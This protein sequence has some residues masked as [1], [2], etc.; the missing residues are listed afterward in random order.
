MSF[1]EVLNRGNEFLEEYPRTSP[2]WNIFSQITCFS[3]VAASKIL[4]SIAYKPQIYN[5]ERLDDAL[6]RSKIENRGLITIMNHMSVADDPFL[7]GVLPLKYYFSV[8]TIRWGL[9][10][11]NVCFT[12]LFHAWFFSLGKVLPTERF[13]RSP[14]QGSIDAA[15]RLL[16]PDNTLDLEYFPRCIK[17]DDLSAADLSSN[18]KSVSSLFNKLKTNF[19]IK[20]SRPSW[21]HVFPEGFVLQ[22]HTPYQNSMRYFRWGVSRLILE[23]TVTPLVLPMFSTGFEKIAP[24]DDSLFKYWGSEINVYFGELINDSTIESFRNEW[25]LLVDKY[26]SGNDLNDVLKY[27]QEARELRSRVAL[28]LREKVANLRHEMAKLP[29]EDERFKDF[30]FWERYTGSEG[31]SDPDVKFIGQNWAIRRLQKH[32]PEYQQESDNDKS[33]K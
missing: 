14:F 33:E 30:K 22:L 26:G 25:K 6:E 27:G 10:A 32:L 8:D 5:L 7:W 13:G 12:K 17:P 23:S 24:E 15:I 1:P 18:G 2:F 21:V 19:P 3:V 31:A 16:S 20:R 4:V 28:L 29:L 11:K 9:A